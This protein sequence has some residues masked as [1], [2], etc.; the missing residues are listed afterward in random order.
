MALNRAVWMAL[1]ASEDIDI[2]VNL[3]IPAAHCTVSMQALEA[4]KHVYSEKP[5][6][7]SLEEGQKMKAL[8]LKKDSKWAVRPIPLWAALTSLLDIY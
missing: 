2:V 7:L 8:S 4:G 3:T 5:L 6:V 1:L